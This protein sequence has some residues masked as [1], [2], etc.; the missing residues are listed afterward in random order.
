MLRS[1]LLKISKEVDTKCKKLYN[2]IDINMLGNAELLKTAKI[3]TLEIAAEAADIKDLAKSLE[4]EEDFY[5]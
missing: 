2:I 4:R 1:E 5:E 3:Y